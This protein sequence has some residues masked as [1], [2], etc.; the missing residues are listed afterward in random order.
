M[1]AVAETA[2]P[3]QKAPEHN[4]TSLDF[5]RPMPRPKVRGIVIDFHCH[6]LAA[7]HAKVWFE[8]AAHYGINAF[9]SMTPFEEVMH[10][11]R[12]WPGRI[13]F[14]VVP[15]WQEMGSLAQ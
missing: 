11:Q 4:R 6:L 14:I 7:R 13:N 5:H 8:T 10:L 3:P 9:L 15:R 2:P 12:D 1:T